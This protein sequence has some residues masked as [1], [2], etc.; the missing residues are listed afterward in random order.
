M[1]DKSAHDISKQNTG[2]PGPKSKDK[3]K[4]TI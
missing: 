1:M 2:T 4:T 3:P